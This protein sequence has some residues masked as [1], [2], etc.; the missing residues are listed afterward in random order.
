MVT[1]H[2]ILHKNK[3][4]VAWGAGNYAKSMFKNNSYIHSF[5]ISYFCD[6][7]PNKWNNKF[8]HYDVLSP[9]TL[10]N[11]TSDI[12]VVILSDAFVNEIIFTLE[13]NGVNQYFVF[14]SHLK[15]TNFNI[16]KNP[17]NENDY[18]SMQLQ[19]YNSDRV[20][21][22]DIVGSYEF[23]EE[24]PYETLLLYKNGDIRKPVLKS[25]SDKKA[26]DI[27]CGEGRMVRRMN[28]IFESVDGADISEKM[29]STAK[30]KTPNSRFYL[31]NGSNCGNAPSDYYDFAYC[32][33]S[34]QHICSFII[35]D[36][37][38][39]DLIRVLKNDGCVTLQMLF[40]EPGFYV[41]MDEFYSSS[42]K[43]RLYQYCGIHTAFFEDRFNASASNSGCDVLITLEELSKIKDYYLQYFYDV[44]YWFWD[45]SIGRNNH[46]KRYLDPKHPNSHINDDYYGT[47]FIFWHLS[48]PKQ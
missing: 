12:I 17:S 34:L 43:T 24:F 32:T 3:K 35:R 6:S 1:M 16:T 20:S 42:M 28:S 31:T 21:T 27:C 37:I 48:K 23:H 5:N 25:F 33:I 18:T 46:G 11:D 36:K 10:F 13:S 19:Q 44:S 26:I 7:D 47:H 38:L 2:D 40:S 4:I 41:K 9:D 45:I 14:P 8:Y 39:Q 22:E 30:K 29:L 15:T